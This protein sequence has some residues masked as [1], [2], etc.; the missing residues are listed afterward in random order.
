[1]EYPPD[2][3][4]YPALIFGVMKI[5]NS[6]IAYPF[7]EYGFIGLAG[8]GIEGNNGMGIFMSVFIES[9]SAF[10]NTP[11]LAGFI[12]N[13]PLISAFVLP[14]ITNSCKSNG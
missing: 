8:N 7:T 14:V 2:A 11:G 4:E 1:M 10:V 12:F 5:P 6:P 9:S 3:K 13:P